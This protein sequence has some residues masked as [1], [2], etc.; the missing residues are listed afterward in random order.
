MINPYKVVKELNFERLAGSENEQKAIE[1]LSKHIREMGLEPRLEPFELVSFDAGTASISVEGKTFPALP[2]GLNNTAVIEGE[3]K[4]M[5]NSEILEYNK[6]AYQDKIVMC[7]GFSRGLAPA[8]KEAKVAAYIG[9]GNPYRTATSLSHRQSSY[10]EGYVNSLTISHDEAIKLRRYDGRR[11]KIEIVQKVEKRTAHNIVVDIPGKGFDRNLTIAGGHY[12]TVAHSVGASDNSGGTVT[13]LKILEFFAKH[14]PQRDLRIVF[15]SGE[16][17]GLLGSQAYVKQHVEE[18]KERVKL[19]VNIDVSGDAIGHDRLQVIGSNE[20][21]GYTDGITKEIG[22]AF[23]TALDIYSS[24]C[25]PFTPYEIPSINLARSGGKA[26]SMIHTPGD[27]VANV[28]PQGYDTTIK[29]SINILSRILNA[30]V[31]PVKKE[32]D[33]SLREKIEKYLYNLAYEKPELEW[34]PKYKK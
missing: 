12:D 10:K 33:D 26:T 34:T 32:I 20:L 13:L 21:L 8:L 14:Q 30:G 23:K 6:G 7:Y 3:L 29:A 22:L 2:Y 16:E 27:S 17:L 18:I 24:D 19:M 5:E 4:V 9:M 28:A 11:I 15:F 25:M 31:Y 1:I